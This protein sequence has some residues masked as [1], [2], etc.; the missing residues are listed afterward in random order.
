M[1]WVAVAVGVGTVAAGAIGASASRSAART[2]AGAADRASAAE[3][4]QFYQTREDMAPWR[5]AGGRALTTLEER[6]PELTRRFSLQ[7]F[8]TDPGYGFR[9][10][11]G[12]KAINR[13]AAARGSWDSGGTGKALTRYG[14][15]FASGEYDKAYN[16]FVQD[17]GNEY[18]RLAGISGTGQTTAQQIGALG[19]GATSRSSD[20]LMTGAAARGAG[21][22][23][24]A[25][26]ITGAAA[27]GF[28]LY[29]QYRLANAFENRMNR[30]NTVYPS[31]PA[32]GDNPEY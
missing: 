12:E 20:A 16:R 8:L 3:L 4:E 5:E 21:S 6:L 30:P 23:G 28:N 10:S 1:S 11:E 26:A 9:L 15:D 31:L 2:Q 7:D 18:N 27:T 22:I 19:A 25:N 29:N 14:Q 32:Y 24:A 17:Q 13:A